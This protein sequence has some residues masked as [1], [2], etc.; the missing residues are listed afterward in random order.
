MNRFAKTKFLDALY[1]ILIMIICMAIMVMTLIALCGC[2][3]VAEVDIIP[4]P[5]P[6]PDFGHLK[7]EFD[8]GGNYE[9]GSIVDDFDIDRGRLR[10][11]R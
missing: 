1:P 9:E 3:L 7:L 2:R 8:T 4:M 6:I 11:V 10:R 5:E